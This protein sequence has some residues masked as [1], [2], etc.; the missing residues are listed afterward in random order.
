EN[1]ENNVK[2]N[3][4]KCLEGEEIH[5]QA[6]YDTPSAGK[7]FWEVSYYPYFEPD[8]TVSG[9]VISIHDLTDR[10]EAEETIQ[11]IAEG[12]SAEVGQDFFERLAEFL[13]DWLKCG[14]G[15]VSELTD[16]TTARALALKVD[17]KQVKDFQYKLSGSPCENV[18]VNGLCH[19]EDG[20]ID[21][22]PEDA[23]LV[24]MNAKGY[25]G[26]PVINKKGDPVGIIAGISHEPLRLPDN[27]ERILQILAARAASE[28]ERKAAEKS[29]KE[30]SHAL[31]ERVK[32]LNCLYNMSSLVEKKDYN[33]EDIYT[34]IADIIPP[35]WQYPDVTCAALYIGEKTYRTSN[36]KD[37]PWKMTADVEVHGIKSGMVEVAYLEEMPQEDEGVFLTEERALINAIASR[38]GK[39]IE[40]HR[41]E[42]AL[43]ESEERYRTLVETSSVGIQISDREGRIILSNPAHHRMLGASEG[44]LIGNY[45]WEY[46]VNE[47]AKESLRNNY[48]RINKEHLDPSP[49]ITK[50]LTIDGRT[51][52]IRVDWDYMRDSKGEVYAICS[53]IADITELKRVEEALSRH[54]EDLEIKVLERTSVVENPQA[55]LIVIQCAVVANTPYRF[56][57]LFAVLFDKLSQCHRRASFVPLIHPHPPLS[58]G[59]E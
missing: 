14:I 7:R 36:Y 44:S 9:I 6:W 13:C 8:N 4:E 47:E 45:I 33:L 55:A 3:L 23:D 1:Y 18:M 29:L 37:T 35:S 59:G 24:T 12:M 25:L 40:R 10:K 27:A 53:I 51:I 41:T 46:S 21:L 52:D 28:L 11:T 49:H 19:Y 22:F 30:K 31:G 26:V 5:F 34:G 42:E 56:V 20:V 50:C 43:K 15:L 32:E 58:G 57:K 54:R 39:I 17:G 16:E 2:N 48:M 38:L